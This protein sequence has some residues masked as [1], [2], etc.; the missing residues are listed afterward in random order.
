MLVFRSMLLHRGIFTE[1]LEN[2]R[3][4]QVFDIFPSPSDYN[5][6]APKILHVPGNETYSDLMI[7]LNRHHLTSNI[8]NVIGFL[9]ALTGC[10]HR[11]EMFSKYFRDKYFYFA[12]EGLRG[13]LEII[14]GQAQEINKY[15]IINKGDDLPSQIREAY[16]YYCYNRQ[17]A[18]YSMLLLL[19]IIFACYVIL[20]TIRKNKRAW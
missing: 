11:H 6:Y 20:T 1:G 14:P 8:I 7:R 3:L 2:R 17:L 15:I 10:G 19:V 9:N 4:I 16:T 13:R 12:S 5:T 18:I